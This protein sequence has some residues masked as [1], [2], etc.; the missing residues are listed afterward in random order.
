MRFLSLLRAR[1][2]A[3]AD[4][5]HGLIGDDHIE[6]TAGADI[7]EALTHLGLQHF[8]NAAAV[9]LFQRFTDTED[10]V[11]TRFEG[12]VHLGVHDLVGLA[13]DGATLA[14]TE[15]DVA[16][17]T[18][19]EHESAGLTGV[20]TA[21]V[22]AHVLS[23]QFHHLGATALNEGLRQGE[24]HKGRHHDH[25]QRAL[26][27]NQTEKGTEELV[28]LSRRIVHLPVGGNDRF[29]EYGGHKTSCF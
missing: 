27:W 24:G 16:H 17:A 14:V 29:A 15:D 4:G 12:G 20:G 21:R 13:K 19:F 8:F 10:R 23:A 25:L 18:F 5:P 6:K 9:A 22:L 3:S 26:L 28:R 2:A 11:Q 7:H 1:S